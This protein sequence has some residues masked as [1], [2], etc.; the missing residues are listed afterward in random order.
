ME[1]IANE[2]GFHHEF[3]RLQQYQRD[4]K[5][6]QK[7]LQARLASLFRGKTKGNIQT[8]CSKLHIQDHIVKV[9]EHLQKRQY[10]IAVISFVFKPLVD[11]FVEKLS[12]DKKNIFAPDLIVND[13]GVYTGELTTPAEANPSCCDALMCKTDAGRMLMERL[14]IKP[15]ECIVVWD[16]RSEMCL[17]RTCGLSLAYK[18]PIP[19]GDIT[20]TNLAEILIYAE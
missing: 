8:T 19:S 13:E 14:H 15:E 2:W 16:G 12:I 18:P 10:Q 11:F 3:Q 5:I 20:I 17:S 9:I 7:S 1:F 6:K 4:G